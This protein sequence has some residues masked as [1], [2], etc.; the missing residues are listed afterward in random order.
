[1]T[2]HAQ[3]EPAARSPRASRAPWGFLGCVALCV[4]LWPLD[5]ALV[6]LMDAHGTRTE[7]ADWFRGLRAL[8]SVYPWLALCAVY[9]LVDSGRRGGSG[10]RLTWS[11]GPFV[12]A[13]PVLA[14]LAAE[15]LKPLIGRARPDARWLLDRTL[16]QADPATFTYVWIPWAERLGA[17]S[18]LGAPSSHAAVSMAGMAALAV[19]HPRG[20]PALL[21]LAA[22]CGLTRVLSRGH[23]ASDVA[24]GAA[25]GLLI[26]WVIVRL[27]RRAHPLPVPPPPPAPAMAPPPARPHAQAHAAAAAS[28]R[29]GS[30]G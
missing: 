23:Y 29:A 11:R 16:D 8:G 28:G 5:A 4:A 20:A 6:P 22:G 7:D 18:D 25:V 30:D 12:V 10:A 21:A 3:E 26:V 19:L 15:L 14:G 9:A 27:G 1:M 2:R 13:A 24:L 17:V